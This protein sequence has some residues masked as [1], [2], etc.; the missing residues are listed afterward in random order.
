M[1]D[2][3][4]G[5]AAPSSRRTLKYP[6]REALP[7]DKMLSQPK[8]IQGPATKYLEVFPASLFHVVVTMRVTP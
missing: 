2:G 6:G 7:L 8:G 5:Q 1:L 3:Q 4:T